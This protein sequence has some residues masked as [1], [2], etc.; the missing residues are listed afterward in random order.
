MTRMKHSYAALGFISFVV[1]ATF[2]T[3][4]ATHEGNPDIRKIAAVFAFLFAIVWL[5]EAV[6]FTMSHLG[7]PLA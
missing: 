6:N 5:F 2:M 4:P 3:V 7:A 1:V